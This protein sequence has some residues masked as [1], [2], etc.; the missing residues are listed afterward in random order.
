VEVPQFNKDGKNIID[1]RLLAEGVYLLINAKN[2]VIGK[3]IK[4]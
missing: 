4:Q 3:F 2:K 1:V